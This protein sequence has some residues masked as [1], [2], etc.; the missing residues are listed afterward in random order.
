MDENNYGQNIYG[1]G[2]AYEG[3]KTKRGGAG[4]AIA[5]A[6]CCALIGGAAGSGITLALNGA[7][8]ADGRGETATVYEA[9]RDYA[10]VS[11]E[12]V[13]SGKSLTD[14]EIYA[15]NVNS[16]VGI[17]TSVTTNYW[18]YTTRS[19]ASGS[20]FIISEDGYIITNEHVIDSSD[21]VTVTTYDGTSYPAVILGYDEKNDVAVLKIE[22][23]G[24]T[25]VVLGNSGSMHV[26]DHVVAI[27]NPLG[28]LTFSLTQGAVSALGREITVSSGVTMELIQTDCAINSGNS[29]GALFNEYGEVIGITNS[30]YSTSSISGAASIDNI[31]FAIPIDN[32]RDIISSIIEK[33][34]FSRPYIGITVGNVTAEAQGYGL[35]AG[36]AVQNVTEGSPAAAAGLQAYDIITAVD[37]KEITSKDELI[38]YIG[39]CDIGSTVELTV[40]RSGETVKLTVTIGEQQQTEATVPAQAPAQQQ[41]PGGSIFD[42]F[43]NFMR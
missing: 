10:E 33:G 16:T 13:G 6:L 28:E 25:P 14:A 29:G 20:G 8:S 18:G 27:G 11:I 31:G 4:K 23:E 42:F 2:A 22:A 43:G 1:E 5:L 39:K 24:L 7:G 32:V 19:S 26:G 15:A 37:A 34:Y 17:T 40:Y 3:R 12:P 41:I 35:P 38:D 9:Q 30:K 21:S 36:A